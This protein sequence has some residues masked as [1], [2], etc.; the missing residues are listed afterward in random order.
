L[1]RVRA[2]S[3]GI[4]RARTAVVGAVLNDF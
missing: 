4:A 1:W 3:E 2:I